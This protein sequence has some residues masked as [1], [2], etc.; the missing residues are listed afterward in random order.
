MKS[1]PGLLRLG[2]GAAV[3]GEERLRRWQ[4]IW[5]QFYETALVGTFA[6]DVKKRP[7]WRKK[8]YAWIVGII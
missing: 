5:S 4:Q 1:T 8:L 7:F 6:H 2:V 3:L